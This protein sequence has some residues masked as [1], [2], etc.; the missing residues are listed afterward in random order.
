[1][2]FLFSLDSRVSCNHDGLSQ[3]WK[4]LLFAELP[5][6]I[7]YSL[8]LI[9]GIGD[10]YKRSGDSPLA[11]PFTSMIEFYNKQAKA[12]SQIILAQYILMSFTVLIWVTSFLALLVAFFVYLPLL[13]KIRGNLKEYCCHKIDKRQVKERS[14]CL[15]YH[16]Y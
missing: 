11:R 13:S 3:G 4:K 12:S 14:S 8:L 10:V 6:I 9:E 7:I 16:K 5:R 15:E 1:M 2:P